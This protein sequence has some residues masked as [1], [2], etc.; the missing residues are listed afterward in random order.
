M[1]RRLRRLRLGIVLCIL[2][3]FNSCRQAEDPTRIDEPYAVQ[4]T[5]DTNQVTVGD[6]IR[7]R[8]DVVHAPGDRV[9]FP[10]P[11]LDGVFTVRDR[12]TATQVVD[13]ELIRTSHLYTLVSFRL[14]AHAVATGMVRVITGE[15]E[16]VES[17]FPE[18]MIEVVSVLGDDEADVSPIKPPIDWPDRFPRWIFI[19]AAITL[20]VLIIAVI[21][22]RL[23]RQRRSNIE[24]PPLP[25]PHVTAL[26]ALRRLLRK[27]YIEANDVDAFYT[28]VSDI[29]RG[30]L[31][32][33]FQL[34]AP[35]STTEEFIRDAANTR[36]LRTSHQLLVRDFLEQ[37]DL[38]KFA[39]FR[40][41][42]SEM[43]E[44]YAAAERLIQETMPDA[45][46]REDE[47]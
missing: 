47:S 45:A 8:L 31:E 18:T 24:L 41:G 25:P 32:A 7:M 3:G 37:S 27:G 39:R 28:E 30:Y 11:E 38:V 1:D 40:P 29:V 5:L 14:G 6:P 12:R 36:I 19:L 4:V 20:A 16:S 34:R 15:G 33:R 17:A 10:D 9:E 35:E 26:E 46:A 42:V 44:A 22:W 21:A 43:K 23:F 13:Q 2:L